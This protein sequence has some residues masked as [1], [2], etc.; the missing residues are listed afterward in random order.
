[1]MGDT[2]G[3]GA[4]TGPSEVTINGQPIQIS[5]IQ[6]RYVSKEQF[7]ALMAKEAFCWTTSETTEDAISGF[8]A[9]FRN[10]II[11]WNLLPNDYRA[12]LL[13]DGADSGKID[14]NKL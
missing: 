7:V 4:A 3:G 9:A 8:N 5:N 1:M 12:A 6:A 13:V 14:M 10:A 11:A 2:S